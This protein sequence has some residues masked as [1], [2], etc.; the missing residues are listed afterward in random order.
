MRKHLAL[1]ALVALMASLTT[2][3][4]AED[5]FLDPSRISWQPI[6]GLMPRMRMGDRPA[7]APKSMH[8]DKE[9]A[10]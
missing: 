3:A 5:D 4:H 10:R 7:D 8:P 1:T 2:P 9:T 6:P